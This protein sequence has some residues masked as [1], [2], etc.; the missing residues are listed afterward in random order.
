MWCSDRRR[1][2]GGARP[3]RLA[4][5]RL[6]R[7]TASFR[8]EINRRPNFDQDGF[9]VTGLLEYR[10]RMFSFGFEQRVTNIDYRSPNRDPFLYHGNSFLIRI[11][12]KFS[13]VL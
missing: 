6:L 7:A 5:P 8:E 9:L 3:K 4:R 11:N 1:G 13:W 2:A 10:V 12:R